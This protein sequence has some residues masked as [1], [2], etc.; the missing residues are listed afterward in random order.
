MART[1]V[2]LLAVVASPILA[3]PP[4]GWLT[5]LDDAIE[6]AKANNQLILVDL[7][8]E[9]CGW[10][11]R[12]EREVYSTDE[13]KSFA[14]D[15]VL[16]HVDTEDG[17]EGARLKERY[18]VISLPTTLIL[19]HNMIKVGEVQGFATSVS[20]IRKIE[21]RIASYRELEQGFERFSDS[22]DPRA[23]TTLASEF[24]QRGDGARAAAL[25]RQLLTVENLGIQETTW[26]RYQLADALRLARDFDLA[27]AELGRARSL[28][29]SEGD[30]GMIERIE[31][32]SAD[33]A[34]D[35]GDCE[36]AKLAYQTFLGRHPV[37]SLRRYAERSLVTI[38]SDT[39]Q[40][41]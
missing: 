37:S 11:K 12:L 40:C 26:A 5:Q 9:W 34:M 30:Q 29:D 2:L 10:C 16:L 4:Q 7:Y 14:K 23:L 41:T 39:G 31:L 35:R 36:R 19:D 20:Y 24:H 13:F 27:E 22:T 18:N 38:D 15:L 8:A 33:I 25:Y 1:L 32:L 6:S 21:H 17:G 28:A 3:E